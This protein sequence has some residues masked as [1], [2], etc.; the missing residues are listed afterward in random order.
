M[1][2]A[3]LDVRVC[4]LWCVLPERELLCVSKKECVCVCVNRLFHVRALHVHAG[5]VVRVLRAVVLLLF[6]VY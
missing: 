6:V 2:D 4:E 5:A 1:R 3:N